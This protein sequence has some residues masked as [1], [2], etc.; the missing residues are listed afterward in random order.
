[1]KKCGRAEMWRWDEKLKIINT[2]IKQASKILYKTEHE[3]VLIFSQELTSSQDL[4][5]NHNKNPNKKQETK[6]QIIYRNI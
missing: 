1:L 2:H 5:H 3:I 4:Y 6:R